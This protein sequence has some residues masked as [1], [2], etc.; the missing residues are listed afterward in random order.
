MRHR[1]SSPLARRAVLVAL[2]FTA[3]LVPAQAGFAATLEL[4]RTIRTSP[5]IGSSVS[6]G[7]NEGSAFVPSD[8]SLWLA[9]DNKDRIYKVRFAGMFYTC[10]AHSQAS[11]K[12]RSWLLDG[13]AE[14]VGA[15][16]GL[17]FRGCSPRGWG[18]DVQPPPPQDDHRI[19][20]LRKLEDHR[21]DAYRELTDRR[22]AL[23][24]ADCRGSCLVGAGGIDL[25]S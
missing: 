22:P 25:P 1:L 15:T 18:E 23:M 2:A 3:L 8:N 4:N 24:R 10:P 12:R 6:M 20:R 17:G 7:D 19:T 11:A 14:E 16:V 13:W 9:D 21:L 5:F